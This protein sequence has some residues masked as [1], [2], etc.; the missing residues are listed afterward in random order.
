MSEHFG[1][2]LDLPFE[3]LLALLIVHLVGKSFILLV[4]IVAIVDETILKAMWGTAIAVGV[5]CL[6][7]GMHSTSYFHLLCFYH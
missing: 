1:V 6:G 2:D 4:I 5:L 7:L 3:L